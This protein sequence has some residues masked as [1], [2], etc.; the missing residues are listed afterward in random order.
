MK[1]LAENL[2]EA[3]EA[4]CGE[5]YL[6]ADETLNEDLQGD[7]KDAVASVAHLQ[8]FVER[9]L[10]GDEDYDLLEELQRGYEGAA[11]AFDT[12]SKAKVDYE[13]P[14][15]H[16][17]NIGIDELSAAA[18]A[19]QT[20]CDHFNGLRSVMEANF[21]GI[22]EKAEQEREV[23]RSIAEASEELAEQGITLDTDDAIE[24]LPNR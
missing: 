5:P 9:D 18:H 15:W 6:D 24:M 11:K 3:Y 23:Y 12:F 20:I 13:G 22:I 10:T 7:L 1:E 8:K 14:P 21:N 16:Y 19:T 17:G 4:A 2:G